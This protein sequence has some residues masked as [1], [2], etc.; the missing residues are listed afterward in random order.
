M[1]KTA[2]FDNYLAEYEHWFDDNYSVFLS[3]LE[4]IRKVVP[5]RSGGVE[6]GIGSG[7][8]AL[9]LGINEGCDP[10][11]SMRKKAV[12]RG[13]NVI[14]SI[15]E[16]LPYTTESFDYAL[17]VTTI[18]FVDNPLQSIREVYRI[19]K[20]DGIFIIGFVDKD[21]P[22]G[23]EY[24]KNKE[25]SLFYKDAVFFST[26]EIYKLLIA[27]GFTIGQTY[28]TVFGKLNDIKEIQQ[29]EK[30]SGKGSFVVIKAKKHE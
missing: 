13:L 20:P 22:V 14:D 23:K 3:E 9:P 18:C 10:S 25:K 11:A 15:A 2:P 19:L 16:N 6:I 29:P 5:A 4:A 7:I 12:G 21:S 1:A 27:G 17:M 8:F 30:G 28:Q 24:I 26:E